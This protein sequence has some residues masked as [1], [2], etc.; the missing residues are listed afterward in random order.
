ME[1]AGK[2][3]FSEAGCPANRIKAL[4]ALLTGHNSHKTIKTALFLSSS[5]AIN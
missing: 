4:K 5:Q 2:C 1:T 3:S